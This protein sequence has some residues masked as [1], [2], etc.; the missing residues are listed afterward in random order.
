MDPNVFE[1][2]KLFGFAHISILVAILT[3]LL[4]MIYS[5]TWRN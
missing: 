5:N 1:F 2:I 4:F 3:S